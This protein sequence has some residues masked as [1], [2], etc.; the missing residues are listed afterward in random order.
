M[1]SKI[2]QVAHN[3]SCG[4]GDAARTLPENTLLAQAVAHE[5]GHKLSLQHTLRGTPPYLTISPRCLSCSFP[6]TCKTLI[7]SNA[8]ISPLPCIRS[9]TKRERM[10]NY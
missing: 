6:T 4:C 8:C 10:R 2:Q 9:I 5:L 7:G 3:V 1:W